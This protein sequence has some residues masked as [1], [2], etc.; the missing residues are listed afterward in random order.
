MPKTNWP[1]ADSSTGNSSV[2][3]IF[4]T[5][6]S[7]YLYGSPLIRYHI[8]ESNKPHGSVITI[9]YVLQ[10]K[11]IKMIINLKFLNAYAHN[12]Y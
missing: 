11:K 12:L 4:V 10:Y 2:K 9:T 1:L 3:E 7:D 8:Y 6:K 5:T